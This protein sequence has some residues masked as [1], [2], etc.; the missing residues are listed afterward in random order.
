MKIL[1]SVMLL[2]IVAM[3]TLSF[4]ATKSGT[5]TAGRG[6]G[7]QIAPTNPGSTTQTALSQI[8]SGTGVMVNLHGGT[9]A[10]VNG[11]LYSLSPSDAAARF[12]NSFNGRVSCIDETGAACD[13]AGAP[14]PPAP[15]PNQV[16]MAVR[17]QACTFLAGGPLQPVSYTQAVYI[18]PVP[19]D[20]T[21]K[22]YVYNYDLV[23]A[24]APVARM[25][26]WRATQSQPMNHSG[27]PRVTIS[28][29]VINE[30]V[31]FPTAGNPMYAFMTGGLVSNLRLTINNYPVKVSLVT[32]QNCAGCMPG[33]PGSLDFTFYPNVGTMGD[34]LS[35]V[36]AGDARTILDSDGYNANDNGGLDGRALQWTTFTAQPVTLG[37]GTYPLQLSGSSAGVNFSVSGS[38]QVLSPSCFQ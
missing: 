9:F 34:A 36:K 4:A 6:P 38:V 2:A 5:Q 26:G 3:A 11:M 16:A 37:P 15:D 31:T 13:P 17:V 18:S 30:L 10:Q 33:E 24:A 1:T 20:S 35:Y 8:A 29:E 32:Q 25:T 7:I 28:G 22:E 27:S 19:Y 14:A 23:P 12:T 21:W